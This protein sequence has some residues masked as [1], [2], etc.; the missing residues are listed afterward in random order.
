[1]ESDD[2]RRINLDV[3]SLVQHFHLAA[4]LLHNLTI[5]SV[6]PFDRTLEF[7]PSFCFSFCFFL[8]VCV[9]VMVVPSD[10]WCL[11]RASREK[12]R[13]SSC[14]VVAGHGGER[15]RQESYPSLQMERKRGKKNF[16]RR[17][18]YPSKKISCHLFLASIFVFY[19]PEFESIIPSIPAVAVAGRCELRSVISL[20]TPSCNH[21]WL[22]H[23]T[24]TT[25][26]LPS[27]FFLSPFPFN[28]PSS[29]HCFPL[30]VGSVGPFI[31]SVYYS[32]LSSLRSRPCTVL[33][34]P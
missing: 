9:V 27:A 31:I 3:A 5:E 30:L 1:V 24:K 16:Q 13:L 2:L 34:G 22:V 32:A 8:W 18:L 26:H 11:S 10:F 29:Y 20:P 23:I 15:A 28:Q 33:G 21:C 19:W 6:N 14:M 4:S 25:T 12:P 7:T 17:T